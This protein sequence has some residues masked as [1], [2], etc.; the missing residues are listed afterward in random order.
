[1][2]SVLSDR[3]SNAQNANDLLEVFKALPIDMLQDIA[4]N[5]IDNISQNE[6]K[7][8]EFKSCSIHKIIPHD[9]IQQTLSFIPYNN[10]VRSVDKTFKAIS[11]KNTKARLNQTNKLINDPNFHTDFDKD[12]TMIFGL[13]TNK[14]LEILTADAPKQYLLTQRKISS[15]YIDNKQIFHSFEDIFDIERDK[16]IIYVEKG[17]YTLSDVDT[18]NFFPEVAIIGI[19]NNV[20]I[21]LSAEIAPDEEYRFQCNNIYFE[22]VTLIG[23]DENYPDCLIL[24]EKSNLWMKLCVIK[25]IY[26][27]IE[28]ADFYAKK[29]RFVTANKVALRRLNI[30][31]KHNFSVL[32]CVFDTNN[33]NSFIEI[34]VC[35][36]WERNI[37][38][39]RGH[40][41]IIANV[42]SGKH[43]E[44]PLMVCHPDM[45]DLHLWGSTDIKDWNENRI[46]IYF[47]NHKT[48]QYNVSEGYGSNHINANEF[49]TKQI[50]T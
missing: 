32:G 38:E 45:Y 4:N 50:K 46:R 8:I 42:F 11:D 3:I 9:V 37:S 15:Q 23:S 25:E 20:I 30:N 7:A 16:I 39:N 29:C 40:I 5:A 34:E 47:L 27:V 43:L 22:N 44:S 1:M 28:D 49:K 10:A 33:M 14:E 41:R 24:I 13:N 2:S 6:R 26:I 19:N 18:N 31:E 21:R 17:E 36:N 12:V 48:I 35:E